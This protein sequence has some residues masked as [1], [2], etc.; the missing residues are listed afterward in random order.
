MSTNKQQ[1][2]IYPI[3]V[4]EETFEREWSDVFWRVFAKD[5]YTWWTPGE[6]WPFANND[7]PKIPLALQPL[8]SSPRHFKGS[9]FD[10]LPHPPDLDPFPIWEILYRVVR[11]AGDDVWLARHFGDFERTIYHEI[12]CGI[13]AAE[14]WPPEEGSRV[15]HG[16]ANIQIRGCGTSG[17]WGLIGDHDEMSIFCA[18]PELMSKFVERAGGQAKLERMFA[19]HLL[20][21][22]LECMYEAVCKRFGWVPLDLLE[23]Q[24]YIDRVYPPR[25]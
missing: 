25:D 6:P 10:E 1:K 7:W 4:D 18:E 2:S 23:L 13:F 22:S 11:E 14:P 8:A 17:R 21:E 12:P 19:A 24:K 9:G 15:R 5:R 16:L 3:D 20:A